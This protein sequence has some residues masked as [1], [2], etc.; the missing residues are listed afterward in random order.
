MGVRVSRANLASAVANEGGVGVIATAGI[1]DFLDSSRA[2]FTGIN[3]LAL[4][5]EIRKA[6]SLTT[7]VLGVNIMVALSDYDNLV[8]TSVEEGI[9]VIIS[10]A[11]LPLNLP[12]FVEGKDTKLIPIVSSART[13]K[14]ICKRWQHHY[15]RLPDAVIVEGPQAGGHL[16]YSYE[17]LEQDTAPELGDILAE[18][19]EF[20]N[21]FTPAIPVIAAGGIFNGA[22]IAYY[23]SKGAAGVQMATRFVCT[24]ECDVHENFKQAY[25]KATAEDVVIIK[26]PVGLPGK[27]IKNAFVEKILSGQTVPFKCNYRCLKSCDPRTAPYCIAKVLAYAAEGRMD[28]SFAFAG[29]NAWKCTEIIP[30]K[31]LVKKL[32]NEYA[33]AVSK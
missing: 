16:G 32:N 10:G 9:D 6:R 31:E 2:Q 23:L 24:D 4:R 17:E 12:Q 25:I 30:V 15:H 27:V 28:E 3:E 11:G 21:T 29:S 26:S 8:Q 13:L 20:A 1:G 18:V 14:I 7:G 19:I 33:Q 22:D 5:E